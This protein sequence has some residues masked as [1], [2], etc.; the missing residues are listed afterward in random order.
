MAML[1]TLLPAIGAAE[2]TPTA[3]APTPTAAAPAERREDEMR[4]E[5]E[6][7]HTLEDIVVTGTRTEYAVDE[8]PVPVQVISR[9]EIR[10]VSALNVAQALDRIP[11]I[12]VK[13]NQQFGLGA[14]TVRMQG[15]EANQ[16]AILRNGRRFRGG[17]NGV[18]DLRDIAVEDVERIEIIRG[19]ASSLYGSD[20]MGGVINI[21][22]REGSRR[23]HASLTVAGG[24]Q[25]SA[26]V[27]ATHGWSVGPFGYFLSYQYSQV[28]L[29]QLYG[30]ISSQFDD[31]DALQIRNDVAAQ[32]DYTPSDDQRANL[33]FDYNPIEEGPLSQRTNTTVGGD[34]RWQVN[35]QWEPSFGG[36][37]YGFTRDNATPGFEEDTTYNDSVVEPRLLR[38]FADGWFGESHLVTAGNRFRLENIDNRTLDGPRVQQDAWLNS[39]YLQDEILFAES[40][41]SVLGASIDQHS[42]YGVDVS[43]RLTLGWRPAKN[44]RLT[45]IVARGYRAPNLLELYSQDYN[46]PPQGGGYVILGNPDLKPETDLAFNLQFDFKPITGLS[47]FVV[48]YRHD[49]DNLIFVNT[50][51]GI[52]PLPPCPPGGPSQ[53]F[54]YENAARALSQGVEMTVSTVPS[55]MAWWPAPEHSLRLDLSYGFLD[56]TCVSGCPLDSDGEELPF[57]PRNRFLPTATYSYLPLGST[58]QLW[59]SYED[60]SEF[61]L[62]NT[63]VIPSYWVMNFKVSGQLNKLFPFID[64]THGMGP[65]LQYLTVFLE[66]Q[67]VL[68]NQVID[69]AAF[70]PQGNVVGR[71]S[72]LA[73]V[74]FEL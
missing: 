59:A 66:G 32:V 74:Q 8:A 55:E 26:L 71:Q 57:R 61:S 72:F 56:S 73:G 70:G 7:A 25:D 1:L 4:R 62:P 15:T 44:Y 64:Q 45:G 46:T 38:T 21:I 13:Q 68:D 67:N 18:V 48:L 3:L 20:A 58:L 22:T 10:S 49:F 50:Q 12:F 51:C 54:E 35:E 60:Q 28:A 11:G 16:V 52:R 43:P 40:V 31:T 5:A 27:S 34:W 47:G 23:P 42:N 19:P 9:E 36:A 29:A 41:S 65:L 33:S 2:P 14:S 63:A 37:W 6:Q 53:I 17:V 39:A 30:A 24:T 69:V